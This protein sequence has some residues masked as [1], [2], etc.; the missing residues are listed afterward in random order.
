[1]EQVHSELGQLI[2]YTVMN[3]Q[4]YSG[5]IKHVHSGIC[6]LG[7]LILYTVMNKQTYSGLIMHIFQANWIFF[8]SGNGL[9]PQVQHIVIR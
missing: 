6:E 5:L 7:Q 8:G 9:L 4:T 3:K 2:L 1:M